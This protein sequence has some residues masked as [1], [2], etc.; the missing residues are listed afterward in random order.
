MKRGELRLSSATRWVLDP[1]VTTGRP[2]P[3]LECALV[4]ANDL[5]D[6]LDRHYRTAKQVLPDDSDE[7]TSLGRVMGELHA[8]YGRMAHLVLRARDVDHPA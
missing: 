7:V 4:R 6:L 8:H 3:D 1:A 5:L 2:V